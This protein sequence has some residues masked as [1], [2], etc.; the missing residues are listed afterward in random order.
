ML[1]DGGPLS[2]FLGARW[3]QIGGRRC[4]R[5]RA[6]KGQLIAGRVG[7]SRGVG[8]G[9]LDERASLQRSSLS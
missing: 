8:G 9:R 3:A 2:A 4:E 5:A 6:E 1:R 7:D